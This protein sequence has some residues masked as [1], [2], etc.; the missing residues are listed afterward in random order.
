MDRIGGRRRR[1]IGVHPD[2]AEVVT[3]TGLHKGACRGIEGLAGRAQY[4]VDERRR[5]VRSQS[6]GPDII[7]LQA[8]RPLGRFL[9]LTFWALSA[10][11]ANAPGPRLRRPHHLV[12]GAVRLMF[13]RIVGS[14]DFKFCLNGAGRTR[15]RVLRPRRAT[16]RK[17]RD[18]A[19]IPRRRC[20]VGRPAR[21]GILLLRQFR[22]APNRGR[23]LS[24]QPKHPPLADALL[25]RGRRIDRRLLC[26]GR[27]KHGC[28][29][30]NDMSA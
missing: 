9:R 7:C 1:R 26:C 20:G 6:A 4:L 21:A 29:L 2:T 22:L 8:C 3:E 23:A 27:G 5:C 12:R 15:R 14:V 18:F 19:E 10:A 13:E 11:G 28:S 24:R 16:E 30:L 17:D 25:V